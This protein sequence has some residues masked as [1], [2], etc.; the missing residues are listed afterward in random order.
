MKLT[1]LLTFSLLICLVFPILASADQYDDAV[2]AMG[3]EDFEK[4]CE[5]LRPLAEDNNPAAQTLL[6]VL[7]FKG[8]GVE[9]DVNKGLAMIMKAANQ[10]HE[11]AKSIAAALNRELA[12]VGE[13]KAM[14]NMGYMCLNGWAGEQDSNSCIKW[15]EKAAENGHSRSA[16]VLSMIYTKGKFGITP[17][18]EKASYWS[19]VAQK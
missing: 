18:K 11:Q 1:R 8:Q 17:D 19:D 3:N 12:A 16:K 4:A 10:G 14:Y 9:R 13:V 15:L 2:A 6:G 5:L 7:Y